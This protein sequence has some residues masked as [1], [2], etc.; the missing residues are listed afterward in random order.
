MH[1]IAI[2]K[3]DIKIPKTD[4]IVWHKNELKEWKG[5]TMVFPYE[6]NDGGI[7]KITISMES[8][9]IDIYINAKCLG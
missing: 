1:I 2:A 8:P 9:L 5:L 3:R 6:H 4:R 7:R